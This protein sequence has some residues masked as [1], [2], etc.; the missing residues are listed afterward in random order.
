MTGGD[1]T[2]RGRA[3][4]EAAARHVEAAGYRIL[5][6]NWRSRFGELDLVA[7]RRDLWLF[8]EV[9]T[10]TGGRYGRGAASVTPRKQRRIVHAARHFLAS[11]GNGRE[12]VR[13]DVIEVGPGPDG[14]AVDHWIEG[15]F[16]AGT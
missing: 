14:L 16:D 8:I 5:A 13:F 2:G 12:R 1:R 3:G 9:K 10:R 4:E 7:G 6:R 11:R 15:A